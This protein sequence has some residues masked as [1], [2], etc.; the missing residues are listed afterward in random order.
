MLNFLQYI[1]QG[2]L[3]LFFHLIPDLPYNI[4]LLK[5]VGALSGERKR[6]FGIVWSPVRSMS[7]MHGYIHNGKALKTIFFVK[8]ISKNCPLNDGVL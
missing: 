6:T 2:F 4:F 7:I 5:S 3:S 1:T 8:Y